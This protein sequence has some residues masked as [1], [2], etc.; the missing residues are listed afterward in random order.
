MKVIS[1]Q[2]GAIRRSLELN[3]ILCEGPT[4]LSPT[5]GDSLNTELGA[6]V[7]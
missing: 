3:D 7:R 1:G 5:E 6:T 4:V 2:A